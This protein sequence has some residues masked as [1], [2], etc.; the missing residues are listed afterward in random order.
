MTEPIEPIAA[1]S[2]IAALLVAMF[3]LFRSL[4]WSRPGPWRRIW[5]LAALAALLFILAEVA[6][7]LDPRQPVGAFSHQLPLFG[8]IL[9]AASGFVA[10][11]FESRRGIERERILALTDALTGLRNRRALHERVAM[12]LEGGEHF[13][14]LWADLDDFRLVNDALGTQAGDAVLREVGLAMVR[15]GRS[16]DLVARVSGDAFAVF[17]SAAEEPAVRAVAE[18]ARSGIRIAAASLPHGR[19]L[20]AS[21]GAAGNA[22]GQTAHQIL[23]NAESAVARASRAGG[24][25]LAYATEAILV[26]LGASPDAALP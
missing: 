11:Y 3:F 18:R 4:P 22:D 12:A 9:A 6:A 2:A 16:V 7:V 13:A 24:G 17:L 26:R 23:D 25:H 20:S 19:T 1:I 21:F 14:V 8:V 10:T 5:F 15:V